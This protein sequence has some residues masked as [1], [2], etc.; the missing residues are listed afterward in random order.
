MIDHDVLER[1]AP[2]SPWLKKVGQDLLEEAEALHQPERAQK[3]R[4][5]LAATK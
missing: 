5:E 3:I 2:G 4:S 1:V